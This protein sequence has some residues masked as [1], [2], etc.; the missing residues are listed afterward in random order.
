M[1]YLLNSFGYTITQ[2]GNYSVAAIALP[3]YSTDPNAIVY[4][5]SMLSFEF[6]QLPTN[7]FDTEL[8]PI[9]RYPD[10]A[11]IDIYFGGNR[12]LESFALNY[13]RQYHKPNFYYNFGSID[14]EGEITVSGFSVY[15]PRNPIRLNIAFS[16]FRFIS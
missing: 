6:T 16:N 10:L 4:R 5:R 9:R 14:K 2:S 3:I 7:L 8:R 11:L 13:Q 1:P 15:F 12:V